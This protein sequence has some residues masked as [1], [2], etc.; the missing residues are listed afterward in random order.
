[1]FSS[2]EYNSGISDSGCDGTATGGLSGS[3]SLVAGSGLTTLGSAAFGSM[4]TKAP[5]AEI[6][7][8]GILCV[9]FPDAIIFMKA[10]F[11]FLLVNKK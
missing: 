11:F 7:S 1:L 3:D 8:G 10:G 5:E 6:A 9:E 2:S 4:A